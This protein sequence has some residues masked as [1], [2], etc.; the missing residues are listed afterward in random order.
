MNFL[1]ELP[2]FRSQT[3]KFVTLINQILRNPAKKFLVAALLVFV[4]LSLARTI[5]RLLPSY[6][7]KLLNIVNF[8]F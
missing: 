5:A 7:N 8:F 4:L 6:M 1:L 3:P 2:I